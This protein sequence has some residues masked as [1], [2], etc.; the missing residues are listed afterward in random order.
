MRL[1]TFRLRSMMIGVIVLALVLTVAVQAIRLRREEALAQFRMAEVHSRAARAAS[2]KTPVPNVVAGQATPALSKSEPKPRYKVLLTCFNGKIDSGSLCST[3]LYQADGTLHKAGK[4]TCGYPGKTSEIEHAFVGRRG[5]KDIYAFTRRFPLG[6]PE[7]STTRR[8]VEFSGDRIKVFED[9]SQ[10][11]V[12]EGG[13][14]SGPSRRSPADLR[15][16]QVT[17][18]RIKP[19][20]K[21]TWT[22]LRITR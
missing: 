11:I 8:E 18:A 16:T 12:I 10:C 5:D 4:L 13:R 22:H 19:W 9:E 6:T 17:G 21:S 2:V 15:G 3:G 1:P 7:M 14:M 20:K